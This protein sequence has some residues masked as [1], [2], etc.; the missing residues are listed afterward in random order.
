MDNIEK[1]HK[2]QLEADKSNDASIWYN[3]A[4]VSNDAGE[5]NNALYFLQ[6]IIQVDPDNFDA[7]ILI[8][9]IYK[10]IDKIV[11][12]EMY[13][14]LH[15]LQPQNPLFLQSLIILSQQIMYFD[16]SI[17][18]INKYFKL[19]K[20][21]AELYSS[22]GYSYYNLKNYNKSEQM[23]KKSLSINSNFLPAIVGLAIV[24][25]INGKTRTA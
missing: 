5:A 10:T 21:S 16:K 2:L 4:V 25:D 1:L 3:C 13:E 15:S 23:Y 11:A 17:D 7:K 20:P 14:E 19:R 12:F 18:Y 8:A 6:K 22:L 24:Y 9:Q